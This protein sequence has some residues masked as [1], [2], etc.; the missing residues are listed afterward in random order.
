M[1]RNDPI[2][3]RTAAALAAAGAATSTD[4]RAVPAHSVSGHLFVTYTA[5]AGAGAYFGMLVEY[6]PGQAGSTWYPLA[7]QDSGSLATAPP[8]GSTK[9]YQWEIFG[10]TVGATVT[11][12][13]AIPIDLRGAGRIRITVREVGATATPGTLGATLGVSVE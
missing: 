5:G 10:P 4:P 2:T 8:K 12:H 6:D 1:L 9:L 13:L 11:S 7:I 3:L